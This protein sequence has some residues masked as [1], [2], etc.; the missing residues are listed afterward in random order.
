MEATTHIHECL[1]CGW[2][3]WENKFLFYFILI[4]L[5]LILNS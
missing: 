2:Q 1:K 3:I 5:I 4:N